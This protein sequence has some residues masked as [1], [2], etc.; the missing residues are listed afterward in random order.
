MLE[1]VIAI[2]ISQESHIGMVCTVADIHFISTLGQLLMHD[3][4]LFAGPP[5]LPLH[6][7]EQPMPLTSRLRHEQVR[8]PR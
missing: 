3:H 6:L 8:C 7:N 2:Y 4:L 5:I 1:T